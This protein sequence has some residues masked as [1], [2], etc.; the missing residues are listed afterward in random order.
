MGAEVEERQVGLGGEP[1]EHDLFEAEPGVV[2]GD[3][4]THGVGVDPFYAVAG[5]WRCWRGRP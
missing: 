5:P 4:D 2:G 3:G 1:I